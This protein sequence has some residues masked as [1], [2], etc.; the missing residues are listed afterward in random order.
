M[1]FH[2]DRPSPVSGSRLDV[3][4]LTVAFGATVAVDHVSFSVPAGSTLAV[5]GPSGSGKSTLLRA[6]AGLDTVTDGSVR[7]DG[8]DQRSVPSHG[9]Q[10]GLMFQDHALFP[11]MD[12]AAN[13][14][15]GLEVRGQRGVEVER[16]VSE[17]LDLVGLSGFARRDVTTLSGGEA[18][19]V[20]LARALAPS[21]R[22][23]ML[24]EPLGS[25][26]RV[27]RE[28]LVVD[29]RQL[30]TDIGLT[31]LHVTHDQQE[32]FSL[33]DEVLIMREGR[34]VQQGSPAAVWARPIDRFTATF[35]GH[36][37]IWEE[38]DHEVLAPVPSL[39]VLAPGE[40]LVSGAASIAAAVRATEFREGRWRL[41]LDE[42]GGQA[43]SIVVDTSR[44]F[45]IGAEVVVQ[46]D[47]AGLH[48][49]SSSPDQQMR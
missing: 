9:R 17:V 4:D 16:R 48:R 44:P 49:L 31:I 30:F 35:L 12:V 29:L 24:D 13:V 2:H 36:S 40:P 6:I 27:L 15:F 19:R 18:Q 11:H 7:I 1:S 33:A 41:F 38:A 45:G 47:S 23:L 26:D 28:R 34:V 14:A 21:P 5:L 20:A 46:V 8:V 43:R 22:M 32:A 3:L 25:L 37:N 39:R 42:L 10:L